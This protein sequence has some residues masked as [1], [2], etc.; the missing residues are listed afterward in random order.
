MKSI[1]QKRKTVPVSLGWLV[2]MT[3]AAFYLYEY[4]LRV[5][6]SSMINYFISSFGASIKDIGHI[7]T[8]YYWTYVPL[9]VFVGTILDIFGVR[10]PLFIA[11]MS[12]LVGSLLFSLE[13]SLAY[14]IAGRALIGFGSAFG[15]VAVL[16][17]AS[18]WLPKRHFPIAIGIATAMGMLGA[19]FGKIFTTS[20]ILS[21]GVKQLLEMTVQFSIALAIISY[22]LVYD[23]QISNKKSSMLR[24]ISSMKKTLIAVIIKP[25][26]WLIG[27]IGLFLYLPTQ[28]FGLW[29]IEFF[30]STRGLP[31]STAA[32]VSSYIYLGWIIG[33]PSMGLISSYLKRKSNLL[34]IGAVAMIACLY[35]IIYSEINSLNTLY[36][37]MLTLGFFSSSQILVFDF[38]TNACKPSHAGTAIAITN[39]IVMLGGFIQN[40]V[41]YLIEANSVNGVISIDSFRVAF[42]ILPTGLVI[43]LILALFVKN[44]IQMQAD[45]D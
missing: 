14:I 44:P 45:Q 9:Q 4:Y 18:V 35:A 19:I 5:M 24:R 34:L 42:M 8:A 12:C 27:F 33:G 17:A 43:T 20:M 1:I 36:A 13:S 39:M 2:T 29:D 25:Q 40:L 21:V 16:K 10:K 11:L 38:A 23:R 31:P 30:A 22:F 28:I 26:I 3:V 41:A 37:L 6:P 7:E 32:S 15:F